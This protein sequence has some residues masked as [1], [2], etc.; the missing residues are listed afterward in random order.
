MLPGFT[1]DQ[2]VGGTRWK[3]GGLAR[4]HDC[5]PQEDVPHPG[6][7]RWNQKKMHRLLKVF[8]NTFFL[9]LSFFNLVLLFSKHL[10]S[11][12]DCAIKFTCSPHYPNMNK[13]NRLKNLFPFLSTSVLLIFMSADP[14]DWEILKGVICYEH[15]QGWVCA[16][17]VT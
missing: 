9:F 11:S 12:D 1:T 15:W 14:M 16:G 4:A 3:A 8:C 10:S 17:C 2:N 5:R 13:L 6:H 7:H